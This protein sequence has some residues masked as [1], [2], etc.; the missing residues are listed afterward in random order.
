MANRLIRKAF[1]LFFKLRKNKDGLT[2]YEFKDRIASVMDFAVKF[3]RTSITLLAFL[4][5][6]IFIYDAGFN[7][8]YKTDHMMYRLWYTLLVLLEI[9]LVTVLILDLR[10]P[11]R[12]RSRLFNLL[13]VVLV[14]FVQ[15]S[16]GEIMSIASE[17]D[18][19]HFLLT[20]GFLYAG[21]IAI[22][23]TEASS[24]IRFIYKKGVNPSFLFVASFFLLIAFGALLLL[25]PNATREPI[26]P[27]DAWFTAASAVCVTGLTVVD[28]ATRFTHIGQLI[29]LALI[30]LGG[31]GIMTF[32]GLLSYLSSGSVSFRN[33][34]ALKDML[35]SNQISS[36]ISLIGRVVVVT[37][38][39]EALGH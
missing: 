34:L 27:V 23:L 7:P 37:F 29:I 36:V 6:G 30:Q 9:F 28:T 3:S 15:W 22:F 5:F 31:L 18:K 2:F 24:V 12:F 14:H 21:S 35:S 8:F 26:R 1:R 20:K 38:F 25:L 11:K 10:E 19:E 39:F 16:C 32:A 4:T 33:Q 13:L 17:V